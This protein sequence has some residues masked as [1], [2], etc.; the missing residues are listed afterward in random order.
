MTAALHL[1]RH[2]HDSRRLPDGGVQPPPPQRRA[3]LRDEPLPITG[4]FPP[5]WAVLGAHGGA[6]T[7]TLA[8]WW[9]PA[10][11]SGLAWPASPRTTQ[12]VIIAARVCMSGLAAAADRLREWH[13]GLAPDGVEVIGLVLTPTRPGAVPAPVRRYRSI[14]TDLIEDVYDIAWHDQLLT[15]ESGDLAQFTPGDPP[16][17]RRLRLHTNVPPDVHQAGSD[18]LQRLAVAKKTLAH[19]HVSEKKP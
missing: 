16:P 17:P 7:T 2:D 6:G 10:A 18:I 19:K 13:A 1:V 8:R 14:V 12:Q 5:L 9:A 15:L 11:D 3:P 4:P